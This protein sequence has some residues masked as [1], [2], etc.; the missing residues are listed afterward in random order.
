MELI[1]FFSI[2][3]V[4]NRNWQVLIGCTISFGNRPDMDGVERF[5]NH[6]LSG[7]A[8]FVLDSLLVIYYR[9]QYSGQF[10]QV[11]LHQRERLVLITEDASLANSLWSV[12]PHINRGCP[13]FGRDCAVLHHWFNA[14][15]SFPLLQGIV[16]CTL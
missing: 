14:I 12:S 8:V 11:S 1:F 13:H 7:E 3:P 16:H 2:C 4:Q 5:S 10:W 6:P 15:F 9:L